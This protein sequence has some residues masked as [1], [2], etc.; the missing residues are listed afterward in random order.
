MYSDIME[1]F[2]E[3]EYKY[4]AS[5]ISLGDF[6]TLM[7]SLVPLNI[8]DVSSWDHY[9]T[10]SED[11]T[12]FQRYRAGN[13]KKELTKKRKIN[14]NNSW[15]RIEVDIPLDVN[16]T[17][18]KIVSEYVGL[19]GYVKNF[20]IYKSCFIYFFENINA[21]YYVVYNEEMKEV[22]KFIEVEVNKD[23]V[24]ELGEEASMQLLK[25][26]EANLTTLGITSKNRLKKSLFEM[27][28]K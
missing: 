14:A 15:K 10:K 23:K 4:D 12:L 13:N 17:T 3:F 19:D 16:N 8:V 20:T 7:D 1:H 6:R 22:G 21:V 25:E 2:K 11:D 9:Y 26:A 27:Y 24:T 18:E 28:R 5:K